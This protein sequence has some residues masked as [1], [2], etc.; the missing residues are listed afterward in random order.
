MFNKIDGFDLS[1]H[2]STLFS[3]Q[4]ATGTISRMSICEE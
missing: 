4:M 1:Y 2:V 3:S